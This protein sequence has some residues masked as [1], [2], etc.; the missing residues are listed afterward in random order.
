M[1]EENA[2][3]VTKPTRRKFTPDEEE[4]GLDEYLSDNIDESDSDGLSDEMEE[5]DEGEDDEEGEEEPVVKKSTATKVTTKATKIT[6]ATKGTKVGKAK[7]TNPKRGYVTKPSAKTKI[8]TKLT[9][10]AIKKAK[11]PYVEDTNERDMSESL[12]FYN[13]RIKIGNQLLSN[14]E[15]DGMMYGRLL[16]NKYVNGVVYSNEIEEKLSTYLM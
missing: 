9:T 8:S 3:Y 14:G 13:L 10:I 16:A 1:S 4:E 6:K 11:V 12:K 7:T 5:D 15:E 2:E